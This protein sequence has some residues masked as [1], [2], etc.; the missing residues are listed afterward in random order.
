MHIGSKQTIGYALIFFGIV[1]TSFFQV[2]DGLI[3]ILG[4]VMFFVGCF[5][6]AKK[7]IESGRS[8]IGHGNYQEEDK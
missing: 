8:D 6:S 5:L 3:I 4:I 1:V 2:L 7:E